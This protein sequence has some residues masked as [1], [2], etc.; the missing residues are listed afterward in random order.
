MSS[1]LDDFFNTVPATKKDLVVVE[2]KA[3]SVSKMQTVYAAA[4]EAFQNQLDTAD[5]VDPKYSA[6]TMEIGAQ[7]LKIALDAAQSESNREVKNKELEAG[8]AGKTVNNLNIIT[9][10]RN[11]ILQQILDADE[12]KVIPSEAKQITDE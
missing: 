2:P 11:S 5:M 10:D 3:E 1:N 6:R 9:A 12:P 4:L 8:P 7:F